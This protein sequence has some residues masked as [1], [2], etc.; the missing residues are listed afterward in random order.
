MTAR[1]DKRIYDMNAKKI[2]RKTIAKIEGIA[3]VKKV[4]QSIYRHKN[5]IK[6]KIADRLNG[7]WSELSEIR[8]NTKREITLFTTRPENIEPHREDFY[9]W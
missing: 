1:Q 7:I 4:R 9:A 3:D 5:I 8:Q 6:P 2:P